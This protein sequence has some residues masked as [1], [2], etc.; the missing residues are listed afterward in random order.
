VYCWGMNGNGQLGQTL[1]NGSVTPIRAGGTL[2]ASEVSAANIAT[3]SAAFTCAES[4][5]RLTTYCWGR[6]DLGQ[7]GNGTTTSDVAVN[8]AP[9]IVVGQKP[10]PVIQVP[11]VN[12]R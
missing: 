1:T 11:I 10:L 9:S 4:K 5:D 8:S 12:G 3:G 6:N 7:L 2:L